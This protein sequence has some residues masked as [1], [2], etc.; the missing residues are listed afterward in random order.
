[1]NVKEAF[2]Q[3][4]RETREKKSMTV[5]ELAE[6]SR[7]TERYI[8]F[9]EKGVYQPSLKKLIDISKALQ[10]DVKELIESV[11]RLS[12]DGNSNIA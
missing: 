8:F 3:V 2:A 7:C 10:V 9:L 1:M 12:T 4:L 5:K 11:S 6:K